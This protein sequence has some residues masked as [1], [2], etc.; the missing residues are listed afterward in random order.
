MAKRVHDISIRVQ[1]EKRASEIKNNLDVNKLVKTVRLK[2]FIEDI[3]DLLTY[4][5]LIMT[6]ISKSFIKTNLY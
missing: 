1:K 4:M 5:E 6:G 2:K 3:L